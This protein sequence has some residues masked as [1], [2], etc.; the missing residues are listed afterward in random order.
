MS[1]VSQDQLVFTE[2]FAALMNEF[3]REKNAHS[4]TLLDFL[5]RRGLLFDETIYEN[6]PVDTPIEVHNTY[7][8]KGLMIAGYVILNIVVGALCGPLFLYTLY[9]GMK[10]IKTQADV[11]NDRLELQEVF[12]KKIIYWQ[13]IKGFSVETKIQVQQRKNFWGNWEEVG[14]STKG[15][16]LNV[17]TK[18]QGLVPLDLEQFGVDYGFKLAGRIVRHAIFFS[19]NPNLARYLDNSISKSLDNSIQKA[20]SIN[21]GVALELA[22]HALILEEANYKFWKIAGKILSYIWPDEA[23]HFLNMALRFNPK[24]W[25]AASL[26]GVCYEK[27]GAMDLAEQHYEFAKNIDPRKAFTLTEFNKSPEDQAMEAFAKQQTKQYVRERRDTDA[28]VVESSMDKYEAKAEIIKLVG[29]KKE[30]D[31]H[32]IRVVSGLDESTIID[33]ATTDLNMELTQ[34]GKLKVKK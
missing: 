34:K 1:D 20:M 28:F 8:N 19:K 32:W 27:L 30:V 5:K 33:I 15:V 16:I 2:N 31:I 3:I 17:H 7:K 14:R 24:D 10:K 18:T 22:I 11:Y 26:M 25:E 12:S 23:T 21:L 13:D 29:D 4:I 6:I 9:L